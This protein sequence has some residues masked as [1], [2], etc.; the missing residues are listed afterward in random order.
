MVGSTSGGIKQV[1]FVV[2]V[3]LIIAEIKKHIHPQAI[4]PIRL[5]GE[6]IDRKIATN[7]LIFTLFYALVSVV[8]VVVLGFSGVDVATSVGAVAACINGVGPGIGLVGPTENYYILPA[9]AKW[10]LTACMLLGRLE[11]FTILVLFSPTFWKR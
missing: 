1:R 5:N 2:V 11:I 3:K 10:V 6:A 8:A 4:V 7:I 9:L